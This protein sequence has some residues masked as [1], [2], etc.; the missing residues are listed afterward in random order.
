MEGQAGEIDVGALAHDLMHR[1]DVRRDLDHRL[2][3]AEPVEIFLAGVALAD[4]ERLGEPPA[5]AARGGDDLEMLG[6]RVL[7]HH[8]LGR[9]GDSGGKVGHGDRPGMDFGLADRDQMLG[10]IPQPE[11]VEVGSAVAGL[12]GLEHLAILAER[13]RPL[14]R[15]R[16]DLR[17]GR[18]L[19]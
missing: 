5:A 15:Q 3:L 4:A 6:P 16:R 1:R 2:R 17:P 9:F 10:E 8:G 14:N 7:E 12:G 13:F 18:C 11:L 19:C